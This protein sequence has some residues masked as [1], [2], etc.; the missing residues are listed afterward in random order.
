MENRIKEKLEYL[1]EM[2]HKY[3]KLNLMTK[4]N[5]RWR[6]DAVNNQIEAL[7]NLIDN[8]PNNEWNECYEEDLKESSTTEFNT[9]QGFPPPL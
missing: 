1:Y 9:C 6:E 2:S 4:N 8:K 7:E 3:K 5:Y